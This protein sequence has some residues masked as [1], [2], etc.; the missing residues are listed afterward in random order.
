MHDLPALPTPGQ[1]GISEGLRRFTDELPRER[2]PILEFVIDVAA[3]TPVDSSVLDLGAGEAPY[4]ELFA[5]TRY[6]TSDWSQSLHPGARD[7]DI[8]APADAL[9]LPEA[10][11]GLVLCTQVLEHV[12]EPSSVLAE[13]FRVLEPGGRLALTVPLLW[14]L[15][16]LPHDY[17]RYTEPGLRHLLDKAGFTSLSITPRSDGF[18][19]VAQLL[20]NLGWAMGDADDGLTA[21]R[22]EAREAL[23]RMAKEIERLRP[24]DTQRIMPLGYCAEGRKP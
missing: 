8:V 17:Y 18:S 22:I 21:Q 4:R 11:F 20:D 23:V 10:S 19:A 2:R 14:E 6:V 13:C 5:H 15:H 16:E 12:P 3:H 9:P 7:A 24:L 1:Q